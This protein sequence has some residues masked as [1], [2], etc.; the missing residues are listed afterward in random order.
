MSK[1]LKIPCSFK[2]TSVWESKEIL[3]IIL[4][5]FFRKIKRDLNYSDMWIPTL[6]HNILSK[7]K[8]DYSANNVEK[9][10]EE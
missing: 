10:W 5:I 7:D 9:Y 1:N 4:I 6:R 8:L 3:E 2:R